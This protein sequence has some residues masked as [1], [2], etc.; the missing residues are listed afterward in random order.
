VSTDFGH[1]ESSIQVKE[2]GILI[3]QSTFL[4]AG[5]YDVSLYPEFVAF[6]EKLSTAYRGKIIF[7]KQL[8]S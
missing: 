1:F 7:R 8:N 5:K 4:P 2:K 3:Q 6:F